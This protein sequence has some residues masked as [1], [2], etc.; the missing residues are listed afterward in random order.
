MAVRRRL[1]ESERKQLLRRTRVVGVVEGAMVV[2]GVGLLVASAWARS[3]ILGM[4]VL[5]AWLLAGPALRR[6]GRG[7]AGRG[8][9]G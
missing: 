1:S 6:F 7:P 8:E 9:G 5:G 2:G 3:Y 4:A